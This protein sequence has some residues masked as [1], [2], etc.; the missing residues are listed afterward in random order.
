MSNLSKELIQ[1]FVDIRNRLYDEL[2]TG[3]I[4]SWDLIEIIKWHVN[5]LDNFGTKLETFLNNKGS[6]AVDGWISVEDGLNFPSKGE[7]VIAFADYGG[8]FVAYRNIRDH[9]IISPEWRLNIPDGTLINI[10]HWQPLPLPP[11]TKHLVTK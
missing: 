4:R 11:K 1:E 2:P 10:T 8:Y 9:W 6:D 3:E 5:A 7:R